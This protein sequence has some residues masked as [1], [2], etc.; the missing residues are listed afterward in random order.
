M[1]KRIDSLRIDLTDKRFGN[2]KVKGLSDKR[3]KYNVLLWECECSCG[4]TIYVAGA[5]LRAGYYK[6]CGCKQPIKRDKGA[7]EH[8][9]KDSVDGTRK[10]ALKAKLHK[11]NKSGVKGVRWIASR[12]RWNA[13]IGFKGKNINLG[14]FLSKEDAVAARKKAEEKYHKPYLE[15]S[16]ET[17]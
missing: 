10:T 14:Y 5:S 12:Q 6:S 15:E 4:N 7:K 1:P 9:K 17:N 2:L 11:G 3:N 13:Y 8:I 16:D